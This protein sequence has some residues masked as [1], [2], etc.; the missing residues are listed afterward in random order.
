MLGDKPLTYKLKKKSRVEITYTIEVYVEIDSCYNVSVKNSH[1][2]L[3]LH[4]IL[5]AGLHVTIQSALTQLR[6]C[7]SH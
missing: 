6:L 5:P 7:L 3:Q 4:F 2:V 1:D